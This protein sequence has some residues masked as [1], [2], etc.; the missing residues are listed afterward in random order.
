MAKGP[1]ALV[2]VGAT[3]FLFLIFTQSL[4]WTTIRWLVPAWGVGICL[5]LV[6]PWYLAVTLATEGEWLR[7]FL[8]REDIGRFLEPMEGHSGPFWI[9]PLLLIA[10]MLPF[11]IFTGQALTLAWRHRSQR[12][13]LVS[14]LAA[15][16]IVIF[17]AFSGTKLPNYITPAFPFVAIIL[18]NYLDTLF[19]PE[20]WRRQ[21]V[22]ALLIGYTLLMIALP[23]GVYLGLDTVPHLAS[24]RNLAYYFIIIPLFGLVAWVFSYRQQ[25]TGMMG[26]LSFSW[27]ALIFLAMYVILPKVEE[28]NPVTQALKHIPANQEVVSYKR[29]NPAFSFYLQRIIPEF[30]SL[31]SLERYVA[32]HPSMI[33]TRERYSVELDSLRPLVPIVFRQRELFE[34]ITI[35]LR[36]TGDGAAIGPVQ[37]KSY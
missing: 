29:Y 18:G 22:P 1:I 3:G 32:Q 14:L 31:D 33:I 24:L 8:F 10:G 23:V 17:F 20:S 37:N 19:Q 26:A 2:L 30:Y 25:A 5:L 7:R 9:I 34:P 6:L 27:I 13:L 21:P 4:R 15:G 16:V 11:S 35:E 36:K 28:L 12:L